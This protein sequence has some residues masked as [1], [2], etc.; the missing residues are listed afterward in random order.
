M[1]WRF[2]LTGLISLSSLVTGAVHIW[3]DYTDNTE[4]SYV[5]K[6]LTM[7]L[8]LLV[9]IMAPQP[10]SLFYKGA[11]L[12][13]LTLALMGDIF[14]MLPGRVLIVGLGLFLWT[15]ILY[16]Y[17]FASLTAWRLPTYW[18]IPLVAYA[19]VMYRVLNPHLREMRIPVLI[20]GGAIL[21]MTWQAI[22]LY[23]QTGAWWALS[24]LVGAI[25]FTISDS[26]LAFDE[27][28]RSVRGASIIVLSTYYL[29]QL[30]IALSLH[31]QLWEWVTN[32]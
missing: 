21:L 3:A 9:A 15:H 32:F 12:T 18:V 26:V 5:F 4:R 6:P 19:F 11:I 16:F 8:I 13:G 14:L 17:A 7:G 10:I 31:H 20:Y 24:A 1:N 23:V 27:F 22:E 2:Y 30:L 25:L 29:A 28:R